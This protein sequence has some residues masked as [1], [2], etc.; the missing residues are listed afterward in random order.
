MITYSQNTT[1]ARTRLDFDAVAEI[2]AAQRR[3][4]RK[5]LRTLRRL[6]RAVHFFGFLCYWAVVLSIVY[7]VALAIMFMLIILS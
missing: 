6:R 7:M 5:K 4:Q 3:A 2:A 1:A